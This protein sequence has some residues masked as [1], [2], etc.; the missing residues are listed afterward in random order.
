MIYCR[1]IIH[2][3]LFHIIYN[4]YKK[5]MIK[6]ITLLTFFLSFFVNLSKVNSKDFEKG[7]K[8]FLDNCSVCHVGG[9]NRILP[10]KNLKKYTLQLNGMDSIEAIRYQVINGKNGMPAFGGRLN[11]NEIQEIANYVLQE[12]WNDN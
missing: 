2:L 3:K 11:I 5:E 6:K 1:Y 9:E 8:L 4:E 10:E 7:K 12:N